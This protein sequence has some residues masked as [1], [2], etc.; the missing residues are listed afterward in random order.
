M[1]PTPDRAAT[2]ERPTLFRA[3]RPAVAT[4]HAPERAPGALSSGAHWGDAAPAGGIL[5]P[6]RCPVPLCQG[7]SSLR[8]RRLPWASSVSAARPAEA[9]GWLAAAG[10]DY[11]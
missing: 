7:G 1:F 5:A 11:F 4:C 8:R 10:R 3:L 2:P 9:L 6:P